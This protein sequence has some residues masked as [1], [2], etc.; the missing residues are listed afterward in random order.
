MEG[1]EGTVAAERLIETEV[2]RLVTERPPLDLLQVALHPAVDARC[3]T[4]DG[5]DREEVLEQRAPRSGEVCGQGTGCHRKP[6]TQHVLANRVVCIAA[7]G[8]PPHDDVLERAPTARREGDLTGRRRAQLRGRAAPPRHLVGIGEDTRPVHRCQP[9]VVLRG[10]RERVDTVVDGGGPIGRR[11]WSTSGT[12]RQRHDHERVFLGRADGQEMGHVVV[13]E[14]GEHPRRDTHRLGDRQPVRQDGTGIPE[15]VAVPTLPVLPGGTPRDAREHQHRRRVFD[16]PVGGGPRQERPVVA[17]T[18]PT[19]GELDRIEM[20]DARRQAR[21]VTTDHVD[22]YGVERAGRGRG[23]QEDRPP[24]DQPRP[25]RHPC[26]K[27]QHTGQLPEPPRPRR[28]V[29]AAGKHLDRRRV[30]LRE[31]NRQGDR[32]EA[33]VVLQR[34]RHVGEIEEVPARADAP[35]GVLGGVV[36]QA[37]DLAIVLRHHGDSTQRG[38]PVRWRR[39]RSLGASSASSATADN[40][41]NVCSPGRAWCLRRP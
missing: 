5:V 40:A 37:G 19:Q 23:P 1:V 16:G 22:L 11:G 15:E 27:E 28:G 36:E 26:R 33:R 17:I 8:T 3:D 41:P 13:H 25:A 35:D 12:T 6:P 4:F 20:V 34:E 2:S 7:S 32:L 31:V 14:A 30:P 39:R 38:Q 21:Q 24:T 29:H 10:G 18:K 9:G